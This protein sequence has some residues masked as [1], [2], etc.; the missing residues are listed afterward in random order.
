M[1]VGC[2]G[3]VCDLSN[4][5]SELSVVME[6]KNQDWVKNIAQAD[7]HNLKK[8]HMD[9]NTA[10]P[11]Q[12]DFSVRTIYGKNMAAQSKDQADGMGT[13]DANK[14][15]EIS[16]ADNDISMLTSK[17]QDELLALL[18]QE[19][20]KSKSAA[21]NRVASGSMHL[22]SSLTANATPTGA[23][24]TAPV[25]AEGSSIPSSAG[26]K[27]RVNGRQGGK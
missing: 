22:V 24:R 13:K 9:P 26:T 21:G 20:R 6:F 15:I 27:G 1:C 2:G 3:D 23:T 17:T 18:V 10:F 11:F 14:N 16:D 25:A 8:K 12:D 5:Q 4:A 7:Q 19:R